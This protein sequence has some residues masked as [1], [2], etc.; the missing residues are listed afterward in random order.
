MQPFT[1]PDFYVPYPARLNPHLESA[2][3]HTKEWARTMGMLDPDPAVWDEAQLDAMDYGLMCAY[4]H[5]D[6][7]AEVLNLVTDWYVWVFYFDDHFL[8]V[9]KRSGDLAGA[10]EYLSRLPAY[11]PAHGT[12]GIP[13]PTNPVERGL[14][15]LWRRTVPG[16]SADWRARFIESTKNLLDESLWELSNINA[17]RVAN[18]MEYIEMRRRVGGAPWSANLVE[19]ANGAEVPARVAGTRPLHVLRDSFSDAVHLRNDLFSYEREVRE[20]GELSNGVLVFEKFFGLDTQPAADAVNDLLNSRLHQFENTVLTELPGLF[21][22]HGLDLSERLAVLA[23]VKGLQDWQ[24]GG[25][26]WHMRSSRYMNGGGRA[27]PTASFLGGPTGLGTSAAKINLLPGLLGP[28]GPKSHMHVPFQRVGP[29]E[30][31]DFYMPVRVRLNPHLDEARREGVEWSERMG[32]HAPLPGLPGPGLWSAE[33]NRGFDFALCAAGIDP[34]STADDLVL[35]TQ[36]LTWGTYADDYF[37]LVFARD[38]AGAK[39]FHARLL[40]FMPLDL[41]AVPTPANPVERAL[42]DLWVR[43]ASPLP[44]DGRQLFR[45]SVITMTESWLWELANHIQNRVPDPVDYMEMRRRTFGSDLTKALSRLAHG[46]SL[47][48]DI[49]QTRTVMGLE[50]ASSDYAM[51]VNDV[52]SYQKEIEFEGEVHNC[53][54]VSQDFFSC[55]KDQGVAVVTDL[56]NARMRQFEHLAAHELPVLFEDLDLGA[57]AREALTDYVKKMQEWMAAVLLWHQKT[58]RYL[59]S[60]LRHPLGPPA[61]AFTPQWSGGGTGGWT[62][63]WT[64]GPTG[65]GTATARIASLLTLGNRSAV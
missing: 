52:F 48:A 53:I 41:G 32:F 37:P 25:H 60:E 5:P 45:D 16:M 4:I 12:D 44:P 29:V 42:A 58:R 10:K 35:S 38:M 24:S 56:A 7:S 34:D 54:L 23:Y 19:V 15:D 6:C 50:N 59:E 3:S 46:R 26:E 13:E 20:E 65:L 39:A 62:G 47:P 9:Y 1:L 8:E 17:G 43:T 18:P 61:S 2:R 33:Q 63:G 22:D 49:Y 11:M 31:P 21:E 57:E 40:E 27:T 30:T 51:L 14:A 55:D 36:W 64:G 28:G